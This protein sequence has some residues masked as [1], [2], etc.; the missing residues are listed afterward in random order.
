MN[1]PKIIIK[2][3]IQQIL[4]NAMQVKQM[5]WTWRLPTL[6][7]QL[8][9][10]NEWSSPSHNHFK[11]SRTLTEIFM[12]ISC[13]IHKIAR[14]KTPGRKSSSETMSCARNA[15]CIAEAEAETI[16]TSC[17]HAAGMRYSPR[18]INEVEP[19]QPQ[20]SYDWQDKI[21]CVK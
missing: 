16:C 13:P 19:R 20:T 5:L 17:N 4:L 18:K 2:E 1:Q 11:H 21:F 8:K 10:A 9:E 15:I 12:A 14:C 6:T 3:Y 7:S